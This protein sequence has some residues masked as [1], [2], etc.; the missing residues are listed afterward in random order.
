METT[1]LTAFWEGIMNQSTDMIF[2]NL[3]FFV[4]IFWAVLAISLIALLFR[5]M[6][7][8]AARMTGY[9]GRKGF[10]KKF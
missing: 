9:K 1:T 10:N 5:A 6:T 4:I 8:A 3:N 2:A 7:T